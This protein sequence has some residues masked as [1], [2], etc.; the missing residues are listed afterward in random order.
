MDDKPN[1]PIVG[2]GG[3]NLPALQ[4]PDGE[5]H[6]PRL[7]AHLP[8]GQVSLVVVQGSL[9]VSINS[10][11]GVAC[12]NQPGAPVGVFLGSEQLLLL[13]SGWQRWGGDTGQELT[14]GRE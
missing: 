10:N 4:V 2:G 1:W 7:A 3:T 8:A 9:L 14:R 12:F 6:R 13:C 11:F 5:L